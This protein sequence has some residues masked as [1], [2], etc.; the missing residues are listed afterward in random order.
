MKL[1]GEIV[2]RDHSEDNG[3]KRDGDLRVGGVGD[4]QGAVDGVLLDLCGEGRVDLSR[5]TAKFDDVAA[6][7]DMDVVKA[8]GAEPACDSLQVGVGRSELFAKV[9]R[10]KP[11]VVGGEIL[12]CCASSK[13]SRAASWAS[14]RLSNNR[15]RLM[16]N[17][18][19]TGPLLKGVVGSLRDAVGHCRRKL[20]TRSNSQTQTDKHQ[21][22]PHRELAAKSSH[23]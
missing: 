17:A 11:L 23:W 22:T 15:M 19:E 4:V 1:F 21:R 7:T 8:L 2:E 9:F 16:G 20:S 6:G 14:L 12:S 10:G 5:S 18:S 3:S 13:D